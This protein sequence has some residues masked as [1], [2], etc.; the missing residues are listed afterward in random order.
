MFSQIAKRVAAPALGKA[1]PQTAVRSFA[2]GHNQGQRSFPVGVPDALKNAGTI[3]N[4]FEQY[5][6]TDESDPTG[7]TMTYLATVPQKFMY[8]SLGRLVVLKLVSSM[9]AS[10]DVLAMSTIEV[11]ISNFALGSNTVVKWRGKPIFIKRRL[12]SEIAAAKADDGKDMRD[13]EADKDR[14][15]NENWLVVLGVCTHLGCVPLHGAGDYVGG[16]FCPCH[17]SHYDQSGR[18]RKGPAPLNL[19]VPPYKFLTETTLLIG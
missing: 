5:R 2:S 10:A 7:R 4:N 1:F 9:S 16:Y 18:I 12:P 11:D 17:G 14:V 15:Q 19:V 13:K 3:D 6:V 8:A